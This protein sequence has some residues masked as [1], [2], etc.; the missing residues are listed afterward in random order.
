MIR[1]DMTTNC[2]TY[3]GSDGQTYTLAQANRA[4][5]KMMLRK[6]RG[7][8]PAYCGNCQGYHLKRA[9]TRPAEMLHSRFGK[10]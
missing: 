4:A 8:A 6:C 10:I 9:Y 5:E 2:P 7:F 1:S 3:G